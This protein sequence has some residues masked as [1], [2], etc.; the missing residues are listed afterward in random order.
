MFAISP[1]CEGPIMG[2]E[3]Q[4]KRGLEREGGGGGGGGADPEEN[5]KED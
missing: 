2:K 3:P 4:M 1:V 5:R